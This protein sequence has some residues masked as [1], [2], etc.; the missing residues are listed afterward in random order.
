M[1]V[2]PE[3][4][5]SCERESI[6][7]IWILIIYWRRTY[8]FSVLISCM[9]KK[10]QKK[11]S[12]QGREMQRDLK[13]PSLILPSAM[14]LHDLYIFLSNLFPLFHCS[15]CM[16]TLNIWSLCLPYCCIYINLSTYSVALLCHW[17]PICVML[18]HGFST[19]SILCALWGTGKLIK[20]RNR[21]HP[22]FIC[23]SQWDVTHRDQ[24]LRWRDFSHCLYI[25]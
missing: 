1:K 10:I 19:T 5:Q 16:P 8:T 23:I 6:N 25:G 7:T 14:F 13:F 20:E 3:G 17:H 21:G 4:T 12:C 11:W 22:L 24:K 18:P 2:K 9:P 15:L